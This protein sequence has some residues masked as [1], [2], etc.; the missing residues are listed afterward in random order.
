MRHE[1]YLYHRIEGGASVRCDLCHHRCEI[2]SGKVGICH[3][4]RNDDGRLVSLVYGEC[5]AMTPDPIEKNPLFHFLP[6]SFS[7]SVATVGCNFRCDFCQNS[8]ISQALRER[9]LDVHAARRTAEEIVD[10]ALAQECESISF[11]YTEPTVFFEYALDT[12]RLAC[13]AG[14]A[15]CFV[16]NGFMT[17]QAVGM[18]APYLHAI[19]VDLKSFREETYREVIGGRLGGVLETLRA[20]RERGVWVEVTTLLIPGMNDSREEIRDIA[21]FLAQLDPGIPW[22]ISRFFPHYKM[23]RTAPT[24]IETIEAAVRIGEEEGLR[25]IYCG[26]VRDERRESTWCAHCGASLVRRSGYT[27]LQCDVGA[28]GACPSCGRICP[29]VWGDPL[30]SA[31]PP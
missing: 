22:H 9:G 3:A 19:N 1:A 26:N 10:A 12:A 31:S 6:G 16:S 8:H 25:Y 13:E 23:P 2:A 27:I 21:R 29:G 28:D 14:L 7:L 18:I 4:R 11:T 17:P 24:P 15:N 20:L 5:V 30:A